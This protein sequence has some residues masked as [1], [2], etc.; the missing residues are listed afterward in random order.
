MFKFIKTNK[1]RTLG[2]ERIKVNI[3]ELLGALTRK[4]RKYHS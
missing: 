3:L 2:T 1:Q 4:Y